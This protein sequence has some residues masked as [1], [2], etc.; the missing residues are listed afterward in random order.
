MGEQIPQNSQTYL[1]RAH[2]FC[3][4]GKFGLLKGKVSSHHA[5]TDCVKGKYGNT[6]GAA[7]ACTHNCPL[8]KAV[9]WQGHSTRQL[10]AETATLDNIKMCREKRH[11]KNASVVHILA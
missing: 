11:A 1:L 7:A 2:T 4:A 6:I 8:V 9:F 10:V 3:Q 5:C